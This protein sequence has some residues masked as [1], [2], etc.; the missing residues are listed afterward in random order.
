MA[1][2]NVELERGLRSADAADADGRALSARGLGQVAPRPRLAAHPQLRLRPRILLLPI[3]LLFH[4]PRPASLLQLL[5]MSHLNCP[6]AKA[7]WDPI[8]T[9]GAPELA[10]VFADNADLVRLIRANVGWNASLVEI[11]DVA[12]NLRIIVRK[13]RT[14]G[15]F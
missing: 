6:G 7:I 4:R 10:D 1:D 12:D 8:K 14:L 3:T 5:W 13:H 15:H 2:A 11:A 9:D